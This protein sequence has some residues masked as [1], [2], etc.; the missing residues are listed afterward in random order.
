[1]ARG[2]GRRACVAVMV[3]SVLPLSGRGVRA[4][5]PPKLHRIGVLDPDP[6][7][8]AANWRA[9]VQELARLG[10]VEGRN[11]VFERR[12]GT[13][14]HAEGVRKFALELAALKVDLIYAA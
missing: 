11:V 13:E 12:F 9:F 1:M 6:N 14:D 7:I 2:L 3:A 5:P 4:A 10:Y 8:H